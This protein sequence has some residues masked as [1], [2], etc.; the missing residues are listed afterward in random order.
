MTQNEFYSKTQGPKT[1]ENYNAMI[2]F[3]IALEVDW[4]NESFEDCKEKIDASM[5]SIMEEV[6]KT[7][8]EYEANTI[9]VNRLG[10]L[11]S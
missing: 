7:S 3:C 1:K 9:L 11:K 8:N 10:K 4:M 5:D 2:R 6:M